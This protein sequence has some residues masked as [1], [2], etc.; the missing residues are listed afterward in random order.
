LEDRR[1][2]ND[3]VSRGMWETIETE[4]GKT[5]MVEA[6]GRREKRRSRKEKGKNGRKTKEAEERKN[7]KCKESS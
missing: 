3:K 1:D 5:G 7:N 6:E 2:Q 4:A